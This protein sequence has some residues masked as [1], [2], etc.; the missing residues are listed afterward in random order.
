MKEI[1]KDKDLIAYCGLYCAACRSYL[2]DRCPG[3]LKNDKNKWCQIR[4]CCLQN[5]YSSCAEC[6]TY[7]DVMGC[8]KFNNIISKLFALIFKS[9]R[10]ACINYIKAHGCEAYAE[11]MTADKKQTM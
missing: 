11:K 4:V 2:N 3:C 9:N 10:C 1:A 6:K 8:K 7:S 5:K